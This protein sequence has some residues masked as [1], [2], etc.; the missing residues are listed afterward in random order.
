MDLVREKEEW[1]VMVAQLFSQGL[2]DR[3][4][5]ICLVAA[6]ADVEE[7][8]DFLQQFGRRVKSARSVLEE[9]EED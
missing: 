5:H 2:L 1:R 8:A 3:E 9:K 4:E 6:E 7:F